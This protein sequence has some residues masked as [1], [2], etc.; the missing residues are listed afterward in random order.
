M[1]RVEASVC[2]RARV[3]H[4]HDDIAGMSAVRGGEGGWF[5]CTRAR[6][7]HPIRT[8]ALGLL[9]ATSA[10]SSL[11]RKGI[12]PSIYWVAGA[13]RQGEG[14]GPQRGGR[15]WILMLV[16]EDGRYL[17]PL[18]IANY[19]TILRRA[20]CRYT[21]ARMIDDGERDILTEFITEK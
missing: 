4:V 7:Y 8:L 9:N 20:R 16:W 19:R 10:C 21:Y 1:A 17:R 18:N 3:R 15:R 14:G 12:Y 6:A 5:L 13:L 2:V 11:V